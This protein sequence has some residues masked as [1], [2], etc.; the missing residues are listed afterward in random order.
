MDRRNTAIGVA[1][2]AD[3][4]HFVTDAFAVV[5]AKLLLFRGQAGTGHVGALLEIRH[6]SSFAGPLGVPLI[7]GKGI[8]DL[9]IDAVIVAQTR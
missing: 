9:R 3:N 4:L 5:T 7:S 6:N 2:E 1:A 8:S